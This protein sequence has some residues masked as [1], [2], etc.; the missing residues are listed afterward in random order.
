MTDALPN[1]TTTPVRALDATDLRGVLSLRGQ[2]T[3]AAC[4]V[5]VSVLDE[6]VID[7]N[8]EPVHLRRRVFV[9]SGKAWRGDRFA[10]VATQR[11]LDLVGAVA[12]V[13]YDAA[14]KVVKGAADRVQ[15]LERQLAKAR[16]ELARATALRET[17]VATVQASIERCD[18]T[19]GG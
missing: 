4:R 1:T 16:D 3:G 19:T 12:A 15:D 6:L 8:A 18:D 5:V 13:T 17:I 10:T 9:E 7:G 14:D 11:E 2:V